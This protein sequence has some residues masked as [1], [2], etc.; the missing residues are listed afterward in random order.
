MSHEMIQGS[1]WQALN[2]AESVRVS[3]L[4]AALPS[5][6][7]ASLPAAIDVVLVLR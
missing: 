3:S 7:A 6:A 4:H 2:E 5:R 1:H